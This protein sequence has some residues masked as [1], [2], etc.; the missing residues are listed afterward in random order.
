MIFSFDLRFSKTITSNSGGELCTFILAVQDNCG[1]D[2]D[3]DV[4]LLKILIRDV[5]FQK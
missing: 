2:I 4:Q 1:D 3:I 5:V